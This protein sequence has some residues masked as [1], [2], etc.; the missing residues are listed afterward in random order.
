VTFIARELTHANWPQSGALL[1]GGLAVAALLMLA[2]SPVGWLAGWWHYSFAFRLMAAS[3]V[4][5][6]AAAIVSLLILVVGW[7]E[8]NIHGVVIAGVALAMG[9]VLAY[10]PW[11]YNR[12]LHRVPRIHDISTDTENPPPFAAVLPMRTAEHAATAVYQGPELSRLQKIAYP[13]VVP[14]QVRL[15][16]AEA[17]ELALE[18]AKAMPGW[19]LVAS[20]PAEGRIEASQMSHW[21]RFTDDIVIRVGAE[22]SGSRI[23]MRSTSRQGRSD[24]GVNAARIRSYMGAVK[25]RIAG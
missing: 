7:T 3:A 15:P 11:Q 6:S 9:V 19:T 24:F 8:L 12:T 21:F 2:L 23:D 13:D 22:G 18:S 10:V 14:L 5:A 1:G 25:Q 17:F 20:E 16:P 4:V